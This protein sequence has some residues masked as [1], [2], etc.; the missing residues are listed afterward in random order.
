[1]YSTK[2]IQN[3]FIADGEIPTSSNLVYIQGGI[4]YRALVR[5][6]SLPLPNLV[7]IT[8][9]T[10]EL[11]AN[12]TDPSVNIY[13]N[14]SLIVYLSRKNT[15]PYDSLVLGTICAPDTSGSQ[16]LYRADIRAMVQQWNIREPNN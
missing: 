1:T 2:S 8:K 3:T 5:F 13:G 16:K 9:A 11:V 15:P 7:S 6:D 12:T 14:D 4:G 10:L